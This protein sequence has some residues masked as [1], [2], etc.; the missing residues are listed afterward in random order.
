MGHNSV[1]CCLLLTFTTHSWVSSGVLSFYIL[2]LGCQHL[3]QIRCSSGLWGAAQIAQYFWQQ[4]F[5]SLELVKYILWWTDNQ[6]PCGMLLAEMFCCCD[7]TIPFILILAE[8][9]LKAT[10]D[11]TIIFTETKLLSSKDA[12]PL[13]LVLVTNGDGT[14]L[15]LQLCEQLLCWLLPDFPAHVVWATDKT[16]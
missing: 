15:T 2:I 4:Y 16:Q 3:S 12:A 8:S 5:G 7:M 9:A 14:N 11:Q 10:L 6:S 13:P 1:N